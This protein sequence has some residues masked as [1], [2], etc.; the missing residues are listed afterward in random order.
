MGYG[1]KL[2]ENLKARHV[3]LDNGVPLIA[4]GLQCEPQMI[5]PCCVD[6]HTWHWNCIFSSIVMQTFLLLVMLSYY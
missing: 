6:Q 1:S 4:H 5:P 3:S 2:G